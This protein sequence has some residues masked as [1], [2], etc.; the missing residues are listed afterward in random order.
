V[1]PARGTHDRE[2]II[3]RYSLDGDGHTTAPADGR[4]AVI[5]AR[6]AWDR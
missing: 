6:I 1:R 4:L 3:G 5:D 2:S